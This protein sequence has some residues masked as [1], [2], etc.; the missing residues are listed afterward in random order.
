MLKRLDRFLDLYE[1]MV[2]CEERHLQM[3]QSARDEMREEAEKAKKALTDLIQGTLP[4]TS[5]GIKRGDA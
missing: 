5:P 1:R 4:F 3:D 2:A